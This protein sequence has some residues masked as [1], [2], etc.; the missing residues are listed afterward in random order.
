MIAPNAFVYPD[1]FTGIAIFRLSAN[2]IRD[3]KE[4]FAISVRFFD[5]F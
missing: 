2:A 1:A 4:C 3:G 5:A